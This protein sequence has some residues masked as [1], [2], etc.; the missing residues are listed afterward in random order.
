MDFKLGIFFVMAVLAVAMF[1]PMVDAEG[2]DPELFTYR[3]QLDE[4]G[5]AVYR[6]VSAATDIDGESMEFTIPFEPT[7]LF[8]A[9]EAASEYAD[10]T[11][12]NALAAVYLSNPMIPYLWNYPVTKIAVDPIVAE[13]GSEGTVYYEVDSVAFTLA[14]PEGITA[15]SMKE[16]EDAL[17]KVS[18]KGD[19]DGKKVKS[20]MSYIDG[21]S[22]KKDED[23]RISNI[24]DAVVNGKTTSA[25]AAQA[26]TQLC[27][28]N[29]IQS[30]TVAGENITAKNEAVNFWNYVYLDDGHNKG[31]NVWY[32]VDAFYNKSA[33]T[34]GSLTLIKYDGKSYSMGAALKT[35]LDLSSPNDLSAPDVIDKKYVPPEEGPTFWDEYGEMVLIAV[36]G[37]I[38]VLGMLYA[39]KTG[40]F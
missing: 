20:I 39:V 7:M 15:E 4:N 14:V 31:S 10:R 2:E 13:K 8:I 34:A 26:F 38:L 17:K 36:I 9:E 25:G 32:I 23:G 35:D 19:T 5:M 28:L 40:N 6:E 3:S 12:Q 1:L 30:I 27:I 21:L 18:I 16:L 11:V 22:Y 33:G 37:A 29:N 24:Y